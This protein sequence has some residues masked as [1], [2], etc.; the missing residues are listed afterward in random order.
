MRDRCS[1]LNRAEGLTS[2]SQ[3]HPSFQAHPAEFSVDQ[4]YLTSCRPRPVLLPESEESQFYEGAEL[5]FSLLS[6]GDAHPW[7]RRVPAE[8]VGAQ[9]LRAGLRFARLVFQVALDDLTRG[10][11]RHG[12]L[13]KERVKITA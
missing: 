6:F 10:G 2:E 7:Y 8:F 1:Q 5:G 4:A 11:V 3:R 13:L 9:S 12:D